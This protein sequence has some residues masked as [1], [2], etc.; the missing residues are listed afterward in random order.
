MKKLSDILSESDID[1]FLIRIN[2]YDDINDKN[3]T[4]DEIDIVFYNNLTMDYERT[5][6]EGCFN[7]MLPGLIENIKNNDSRF[8]NRACLSFKLDSDNEWKSVYTLFS[9]EKERVNEDWF[10]C[11]KE[12]INS[13]IKRLTEENSVLQ[14]FFNHKLI[15]DF[16]L[17]EQTSYKINITYNPIERN[18]T[19]N[20][21]T[22]VSGSSLP[23]ELDQGIQNAFNSFAL[24]LVMRWE[25]DEAEDGFGTISID[26]N[27]TG[28]HLRKW[29]RHSFPSTPKIK[30]HQWV[31]QDAVAIMMSSTPGN[32]FQLPA[33]V[34]MLGDTIT[35]V[36]LGESSNYDD[37]EFNWDEIDGC[38]TLSH[39]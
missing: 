36:E 1:R 7:S 26:M 23:V 38:V 20:L 34:K 17:A 15:S 8:C 11:Y 5:W 28:F 16:Y 22:T 18:L 37:F 10:S 27:D 14:S 19:T 24:D 25:E 3:N 13:D 31:T 39:G 4:L 6:M 29:D 2:R 12:N 30:D 33:N 32:P 21:T 35:G 9:I